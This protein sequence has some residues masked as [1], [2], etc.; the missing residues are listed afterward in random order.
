M[1]CYLKLFKR[2][3]KI[4][5]KEN[6]LFCFYDEL[7]ENPSKYYDKISKFIGIDPSLLPGNIRK[8]LYKKKYIGPL[9]DFPEKYKI[10]KVQQVVY[11]QETT[12]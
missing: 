4:I 6:I 9:V 12:C 8:T 5:P 10:P 1:P 3:Q 7:V 11:F 2:W